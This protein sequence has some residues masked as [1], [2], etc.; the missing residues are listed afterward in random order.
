VTEEKRPRRWR[1]SAIALLGLA[2]LIAGGGVAAALNAS[3]AGSPVHTVA[4]SSG[5]STA[6]TT[7]S[8]ESYTVTGPR[9]APIVFRPPGLSRAQKVGLVVAFY[10]ATGTPQRMEGL[11]KFEGAAAA[12]GF[13]VVYPGSQTDPPWHAA[14]DT[15]YLGSLIDRIVAQE[16]IDPRRIYLTG[17]SAGGRETYFL[18]CRLSAK[19]AAIAVVSSVMRDYPCA[20]A[21]PISEL[22]IAGSQE[23]VNGTNGGPSVASVA[24]RWRALDGCSAQ[25]PMRTTQ[26]AT[27][28]Q[29]SW[30]PCA[31]GSAVGIW[32]VNG[33]HH[34]WP[35]T[36]GLAASDPDAQFDAT[37]AIWSFF[38]AHPS[39]G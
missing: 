2:A 11:T 20:I 37:E 25:A 4:R 13:V 28:T 3:G 9:P 36:Y 34:T 12:H 1:P 39:P 18:G 21:H 32:I 14:D 23:P 17:F 33:G 8:T 31:A 7:T 16:N 38:A 6:A 19:V 5:G 24:A 26:V 10:G 22:T 15:A 27:V 35:G 30:G 29:Q